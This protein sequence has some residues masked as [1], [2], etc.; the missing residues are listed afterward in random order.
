MVTDGPIQIIRCEDEEQWLH[1]RRHSIGASQVGDVLG[2]GYTTPLQLYLR[3][4]GQLDW[5]DDSER[6]AI[7]RE[8]EPVIASLWSR[9]SGRKV[10][11]DR[12]WPYTI[13]RHRNYPWLHSTPD[14]FVLPRAQYVEAVLELKNWSSFQRSAIEAEGPTF[15]HQLQNHT[16]MITTG[17]EAGVIAYLFGNETVIGFDMAPDEHVHH[18]IIE[19]THAFWDRLEQ[20]RPPE[21]QADD[22]A[23]I[24]RLWP[25]HAPDKVVTLDEA[26]DTLV[27]NWCAAKEAVKDHTSRKNKLEAEIRQL[28]GDAEAA[29]LPS[30]RL[31]TAKMQVTKEHVRRESTSRPLRLKAPKA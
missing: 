25:E 29:H 5:P 14:G 21:P 24:K 1:E 7:G 15:G 9:K 18:T 20:D 4:K 19:E 8:M 6:F 26:A 3:F 13:Y 22:L 28:M 27:D 12:S 31:L 10:D 2:L 17:T 16:Q 23:T 30:G 11:P